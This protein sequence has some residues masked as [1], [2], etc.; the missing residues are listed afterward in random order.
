MKKIFSKKIIVC[1][2]A[3]SL[4]GSCKIP[5]DPPLKSS[6]TNS[7]VVEGYID[8]AAPTIFT[9]SRSRILSNG[10][11]ATRKLEL[12]ARVLVEDDHQ[13]SFLLTE[14][15]DGVY[16]SI[17]VLNLTPASKYRLHIFTSD[18][19]EYVSDL[20]SFK[21]SAPIDSI[22]WSIKDDG[23]QTFVNTHDPSN[24]TR[25]YRWSFSETWEVH[26]YYYSTYEYIS[27]TNSVVPRTNQVYQCW[28]SD[29]STGILLG[30]S[31]KLTN[32]VINQAPL[33]YIAPHDSKLNVLYS[34]L[35]K[36]Y[37]LDAD[38]YN[39]WVAMKSN[40]EN[41]GS[42]FDPQPNQTT[43]NIHCVTD[44]SETVV[45]Y[46]GAG[47]SVEKRMFIQNSSLPTGW[48]TWPAC[49]LLIVPDIPDSLKFYFANGYEPIEPTWPPGGYESS[50]SECVD[51]TLF[52]T[53]V[54]PLFWP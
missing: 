33:V 27:S 23:V 32:D 28:R 26:S 53:N 51:C 54:K 41:V 2:L 10:D 40:T 30:S 39:Y 31:A 15:G 3:I 47:N 49:E 43:G 14:T 29:N 42:I 22:G 50:S 24:S 6:D 21:Q 1:I 35:V 44:A 9:L 8:G 48:N 52:G 12:H 46:V 16:A 4:A 17:D 38:G 19:R 5:Y 45:G 11:T 37:A 25:Y 36:Q 20:V 34:I 13:N 7:L 18:A